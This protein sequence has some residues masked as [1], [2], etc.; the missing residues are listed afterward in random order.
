[1]KEFKQIAEWMSRNPDVGHDSPIVSSLPS[2]NFE[3]DG[4]PYTSFST[5]NYLALA[6]SRRLV[7]AAQR[8]L[9]KYGVANCESRLLGGDLDVYREVEFKLAHLKK[10]SG[11]I[12]YATGY[13]TNLGAL[14]SLVR[15]PLI[16]RAYGFRPTS[17]M[18]YAFFTDEYNH[19]SIREGIRLSGADRFTYRHADLNHLEMLLRENDAHS[20][21]IVSDGVFSQD[22]DIAALPDLLNLAEKYDAM[23]YID[24]A[25]GTGVLGPNGGGISEHF[26]CYHERLIHMGTLSKAYGAIGGFVAAD[27]WICEILRLTSPAYGFTSTLPPD[28]A[29]AVSEAIDMVTDEPERRLSLWENQRM[30]VNQ[31][32]SQDFEIV[33]TQTP[34]V[35]VIIGD[36]CASDEFARQLRGFGFYVDS[37]KFPAVAKG[38]ARL[39]II[40]N[41]HHTRE[42]IQALAHA[43]VVVREINRVPSAQLAVV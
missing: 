43:M 41:A 35:P 42:Q 15:S 6:T 16:C 27:E 19:I 33:S 3:M 39:R 18:T 17:R 1:M 36:D 32:L 24:D 8:G 29:F 37:V 38:K 13:L 40:L 10:K 11:S 28:Q 21:I 5:N 14:S 22:G 7:A 23:V 26:Q 31:M 20:K 9:D 34:I 4:K 12:L 2:P 30:F 25:H